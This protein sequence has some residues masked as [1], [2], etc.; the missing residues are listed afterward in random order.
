MLDG[1]IV[2]NL[3]LEADSVDGAPPKRLTREVRITVPWAAIKEVGVARAFKDA[4]SME[5]YKDLLLLDED[6]IMKLG[7]T[8]K[9]AD[10]P[11]P[12]GPQKPGSGRGPIMVTA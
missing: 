12:T 4:L 9:S 2:V 11:K 10:V 6:A 8:G 5:V 7:H 3:L 1:T